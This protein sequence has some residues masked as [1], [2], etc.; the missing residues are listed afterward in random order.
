MSFHGHL[1]NSQTIF[2]PVKYWKLFPLII[3]HGMYHIFVFTLLRFM[4]DKNLARYIFV[5]DMLTHLH[6]KL[7][8]MCFM[9]RNKLE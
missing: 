7:V 2:I 8:D 6:Y 3:N 4:Q 9:T 1:G 5:V